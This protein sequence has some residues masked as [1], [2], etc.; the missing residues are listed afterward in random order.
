[1]PVI[2]PLTHDDLDALLEVQR[3]GAVAGLGH[4]FP[5]AEHPFPTAQV[6]ARWAAEIDDPGTDCFAVVLDGVLAGFAATHDDELLHFGTA[7][8]TWGSGLAHR[9]H[10]EVLD[11]LRGRGH[12]RA[13]LRVFDENRRAVRFYVRHGWRATDVTSRTAFPP[14]PLLRR[15]ELDLTD[16]PS[17][18]ASTTHVRAASVDTTPVH[19]L[20]AATV[21]VV[22]AARGFLLSR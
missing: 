1:M 16:G 8:H 6:R 21:A 17:T 7:L 10:D 20:G 22:V 14:H 2:R 13:W 9:A 18:W 11:H 12:R 5:Q 15:Y 4:I 3:E 19:D